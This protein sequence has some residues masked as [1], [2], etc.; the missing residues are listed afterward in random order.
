MQLF[1]C[2]QLTHGHGRCAVELVKTE[3]YIPEMHGDM[4]LL[5]E[6]RFK[7]FSFLGS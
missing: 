4:F 6:L 7:D 3:A 1:Y 2:D 5:Y